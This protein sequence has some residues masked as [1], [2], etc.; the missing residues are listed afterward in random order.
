MLELEEKGESKMGRKKELTE[1][2]FKNLLTKASQPVAGQQ[3]PEPD[4]TSEKT[5]GSPISGDCSDTG[6]H[7]DTTGDI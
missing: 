2:D 4:S 6:I 3:P 7:S 5:S 1:K